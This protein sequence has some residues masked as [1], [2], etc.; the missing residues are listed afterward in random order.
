MESFI[1]KPKYVEGVDKSH[2]KQLIP[3]QLQDEAMTGVSIWKLTNFWLKEFRVV[4]GSFTIFLSF[5]ILIAFLGAEIF[6]LLTFFSFYCFILNLVRF[7]FTSLKISF[8]NSL[9]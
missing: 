8:S 6:F 3:E 1:C 5:F 2:L 9:S 4:R 7:S